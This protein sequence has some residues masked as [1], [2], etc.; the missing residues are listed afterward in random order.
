MR[1]FIAAGGAAVILFFVLFPDWRAVRISDPT[2]SEFI[3]YAWL[4]SPPAVPAGTT[5]AKGMMWMFLSA[6]AGI[7]TLVTCLSLA[8][9]PEANQSTAGSDG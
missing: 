3:G 1:T 8:A 7:T 4:W 2:I 6:V 9:A 5:L